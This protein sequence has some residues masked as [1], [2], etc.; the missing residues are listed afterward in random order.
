VSSE[1]LPQAHEG[2]HDSTLTQEA[3]VA[4]KDAGEHRALVKGYDA[5]FKVVFEAFASL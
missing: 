2:A 3:R 4:A 5:Q 1:H